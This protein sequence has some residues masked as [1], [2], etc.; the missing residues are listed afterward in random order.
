MNK[1][2]DE[3]Q[4]P[5]IVCGERGRKKRFCSNL[6]GVRWHRRNYKPKPILSDIRLSKIAD[7]YRT[8]K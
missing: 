4:G 3:C 1:T 8:G 6:C 2:C 7:F 5:L